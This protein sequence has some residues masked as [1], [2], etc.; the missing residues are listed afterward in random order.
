MLLNERISNESQIIESDSTKLPQ[1]IL[2][3]IRRTVCEIGKKNA[4]NRLYEKAVWEKVLADGE[5]KKRLENRQILGEMEH[6][7]AS[8]I[9]LDKDRTSH[10]VSNL[11]IDE[12][13]GTVKADF[14]LL[15]T[16]AGK[17]IW[18][19]HEAGVK[20]PASTRADGELI[21]EIDETGNKFNKVVPE[22]YS[23][24][25]IDH[26][27]DPSCSNTEPE[28]IVSA[29][30]SNYEAHKIGKNVAMALLEKAGTAEAKKLE[31][32]I[33][34]DKQHSDC[35]CKV[36][37][38]KCSNGCSH[39]KE[40][41]RGN[42]QLKSLKED[43]QNTSSAY[44]FGKFESDGPFYA[45]DID[46]MVKL[47]NEDL[48]M[49]AIRDEDKGKIFLSYPKQ[50]VKEE[51]QPTKVVW[52]YAVDPKYA[53][54]V[55]INAGKFSPDFAD[56]SP[57][58]RK[59]DIV[60][61]GGKKVI[62]T[63][64][65]SLDEPKPY[66]GLILDDAELGKEI[67]FSEKEVQES[68]IDEP[69][70]IG[71][72]VIVNAGKY[73]NASGVI[74]DMGIKGNN[75]KVKFADSEA[76]I[77]P[78]DIVKESKVNEDYQDKKLELKN[79][80]LKGL[81]DLGFV[82]NKGWG[83]E[84]EISNEVLGDEPEVR[85]ITQELSDLEKE[86]YIESRNTKEG[87]QYRLKESK[88]NEERFHKCN[89]CGELYQVEGETTVCP[90][91]GTATPAYSTAHSIGIDNESKNP[92]QK[93]AYKNTL[94][95]LEDALKVAKQGLALI[96][97]E[98]SPD[99]IGEA[100]KTIKGIEDD[101][102]RV[103]KKMD[104]AKIKRLC[105]KCGTP[106]E[107]DQKTSGPWGTMW[108]CPT[109]GL[110]SSQDINYVEESKINE[111]F[112]VQLG[113]DGEVIIVKTLDEVV[114][115]LK[116]QKIRNQVTN[117]VESDDYTTPNQ[118][119]VH[120]ADASGKYVK[121]LSKEEYSELA[122]KVNEAKVKEEI[123]RCSKC[124]EI[125]DIK[126][127]ESGLCPE[128][129][130]KE[131]KLKEDYQD[132]NTKI[133]HDFV[134]SACGG[135]VTQE[136][137]GKGKSRCCGAEVVDEKTWDERDAKDME[138]NKINEKLTNEEW[139]KVQDAVADIMQN[140]QKITGV[141]PVT[142]ID[143]EGAFNDKVIMDTLGPIDDY[144]KEKYPDVA[145]MPMRDEFFVLLDD[146]LMDRYAD[147]AVKRFGMK[148]SRVT[149]TMIKMKE[150]RIRLATAKAEKDKLLETLVETQNNYKKDILTKV[151]PIVE[152][153]EV[154]VEKVVE[155]PVEKLVPV[156]ETKVLTEIETLKKKAVTLENTLKE[157][158]VKNDKLVEKI[159]SEHKTEIE[160]LKEKTNKE[161]ISTYTE[162]LLDTTGLQLPEATLALLKEAKSKEEVNQIV[163]SAKKALMIGYPHSG[164][165]GEI[166]VESQIPVDPTV[167]GI[168]ERVNKAFESMNPGKKTVK[169]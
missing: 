34:M 16:E 144:L 136:E 97:E 8:Q 161:I 29:V 76:I 95:E 55:G 130:A 169:K 28:N 127:T 47:S 155:K 50:I 118:I 117:G 67:E 133:A 46:K 62:L 146:K 121:D 41:R 10:I 72:K 64:L 107:V 75:Y 11:F 138:E 160:Q 162:T 14:D 27:G 114:P 4:N 74:T 166:K 137:M 110:I 20:V 42:E 165:L 7:E 85:T 58:F 89:K 100:E 35:K 33:K 18:I 109:H 51:G 77:F 156:V 150:M 73:K 126:E 52:A 131:D 70:K 147:E 36:G 61:V 15:P 159:N 79:L 152:T 31:E 115:I 80:I 69:I 163:E 57:K 86:G 119:Y 149:K 106:L 142:T 26:T 105:P 24:I 125:Y 32:N 99:K 54:G 17:F 43:N 38:K 84:V 154:I 164:K 78:Q 167:K 145:V 112:L 5:F 68:K 116:G 49:F 113:K 143:P 128:C 122:R 44:Y 40:D 129:L 83:Y 53:S 66:A 6:P 120:Y 140:F 56:E 23:F 153:K 111:E 108:K 71:D 132:D 81:K 168:E 123:N 139:A 87:K 124:G 92:L 158:K 9:K 151:E 104:E 134:C 13:T 98:G 3:R 93:K 141:D 102:A 148:E 22:T 45:E 21:E 96:K 19:L 12:S 2:A 157:E 82:G 88:I 94:I 59:N 65:G 25:T 103:Q 30:K 39:I 37:E 91:C 101:I 90:K 63:H 48:E 1:G 60:K 135:V